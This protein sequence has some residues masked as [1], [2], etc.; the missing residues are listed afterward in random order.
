MFR[1]ALKD[2]F[3]FY[4]HPLICN[5]DMK[6][7]NIFSP[8]KFGLNSYLF[9]TNFSLFFSLLTFP[10]RR[11][12]FVCPER[13]TDIRICGL[14]IILKTGARYGTCRDNRHYIK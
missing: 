1:K 12:P 4:K 14:F 6:S 2:V 13:R 11:F 9:L 10:W 5:L 8:K 3:Q 7:H